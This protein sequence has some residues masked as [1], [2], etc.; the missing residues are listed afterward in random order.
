MPCKQTLGQPTPDTSGTQWLE[1]LFQGKQPP[2]PFLISTFASSE[3][4]L[5]PF[6]EPSQHDEPP[7]PGTSQA[8]DSQ[9]PSHENNLTCEPEPEVAPTQSLEEPCACPS[10][11]RSFI[12]INDTPIGTPT[13][14]C[15]PVASKNPMVPSLPASS[16]PHSSNEALQEFNDWSPMLM[17]PQAIIHES[18]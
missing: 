4:T 8:S 6:V 9:L 1:D 7:I 12:I 2:F 15:P 14:W 18:C 17:F 11:P 5:P 10:T 16:S 13:P 3:L